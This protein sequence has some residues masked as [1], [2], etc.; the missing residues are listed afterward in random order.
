M[1]LHVKY[2]VLE[3]CKCSVTSN[4]TKPLWASSPC[5]PLSVCLKSQIKKFG[6]PTIPKQK[7]EEKVTA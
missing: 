2:D 5:K 7:H 4:V 1:T 6:F 3:R